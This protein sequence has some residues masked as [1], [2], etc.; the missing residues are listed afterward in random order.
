MQLTRSRCSGRYNVAEVLTLRLA[1][2]FV[3]GEEKSVILAYGPACGRA[4]LNAMEGR[5]FRSVEEISCV[6][7]FV[8]V[9]DIG[10]AMKIVGARPR[11][12]IDNGA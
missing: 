6:E 11:D 10:A 5:D 12:R 4:K 1:N 2:S 9:K 8:A 3:I 7:Y